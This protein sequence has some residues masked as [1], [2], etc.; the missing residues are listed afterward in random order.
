V[1]SG[2]S[3]P[4]EMQAAGLLDAEPADV[5]LLGAVFAGPSP[6]ILDTF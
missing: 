4:S 5:A 3:H 1:F 6:F 2:F